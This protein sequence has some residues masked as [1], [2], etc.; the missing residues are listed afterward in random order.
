MLS[1]PPLRKTEPRNPTL[2]TLIKLLNA[3]DYDTQVASGQ[4]PKGST[5]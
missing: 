5:G 1:A 3:P 2:T 4:C